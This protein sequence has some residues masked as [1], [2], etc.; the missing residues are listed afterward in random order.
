MRDLQT[1]LDQNGNVATALGDTTVTFDGVTAPLLSANSAEIIAVV[2]YETAGKS[3]TTMTVTYHGGSQTVV[4]G[5][6][7]TSPGI[8]PD[9]VL[10]NPNHPA[11]AG[12]TLSIRATG[13]GQTNPPGVTGRPPIQVLPVPL[14]SVTISVG[15]TAADII[16]AGAEPGII[17]TILI[18]F[19]VPDSLLPGDYPL[20]LKIGSISTSRRLSIK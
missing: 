5:T 14:A 1:A 10:D 16:Y 6:A 11:A 20:T 12:S 13:E 4:L 7:T 15:S 19:R 18:T 8:F 3:S 17:G 9:P 2:P